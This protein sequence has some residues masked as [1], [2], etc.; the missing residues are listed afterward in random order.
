M[1]VVSYILK[2]KYFLQQIGKNKIQKG[3]KRENEAKFYNINIQHGT[4][5]I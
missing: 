3:T 5:Y 2:N 4:Y 1:L